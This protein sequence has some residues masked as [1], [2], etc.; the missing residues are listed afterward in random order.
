MTDR[1]SACRS[2]KLLHAA[3]SWGVLTAKDE[4]LVHTAI[5]W[6]FR[7]VFAADASVNIDVGD[8]DI[9]KQLGIVMPSHMMRRMRIR[10]WARLIN[11]PSEDAMSIAFL[12]QM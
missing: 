5:M 9:I 3:S 4:H 1:K 2:T 12:R 10:Y 11:K 6:I 8:D 7:Q